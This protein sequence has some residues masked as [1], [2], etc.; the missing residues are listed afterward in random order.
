MKNSLTITVAATLLSSI[1]FAQGDCGSATHLGDAPILA[2][3]FNTSTAT[4][5]GV[6]PG[7][8][9][10]TPPTDL[11]FSFTTNATETSY[12][13]STCGFV[14]YD[15]RLG[16]YDSCGSS[17]I[18]CNDDT[19]GL[20]SAL[21]VHGLS[22]STTYFVQVGGFN[23]AA[24]NGALDITPMMAPPPP[25][26]G[27]DIA[28]SG[29]GASGTINHGLSG[30]R[31]AYSFG[32]TSCNVGDAPVNW[33][34]GIGNDHPVIGQNMFRIDNGRIE[35]LGYSFLKHGFFALSQPGCA[36]TPCQ[37]TNG[38]QLGIGC[39][40]T[41]GPGLNDGTDGASKSSVNAT[42]GTYNGNPGP[43][44]D[45]G[46]I[47]GRLQVKDSELTGTLLIEGQYVSEHD[48]SWGLARNNVSWIRVNASG[49]GN[50]SLSGS[51]TRYEPG[52][53]A[54]RDLA[55]A[56]VND[57]PNIDEGG[58]DVHGWYFV[59][60]DVTD[61]GGGQW[62][63][64]YAVQN[65]NSDQSARSFTIPLPCAGTTTTDMFFRDVD[66]HSGDPYSN[67]DWSFTNNG[68]SAVWSTETFAQNQDANALRWGTLYNFGFTSNGAPQ[69]VTASLGMFKPGVATSVTTTVDGPCA[70]INP[71][72][73]NAINY[74]TGNPNSS[75]PG[76]T[77]SITGSTQ[78]SANDL[79][80]V[81][82]GATP[83]ESGVFYYG[84]SQ[85]DASFGEG[86]RCVGGTTTRLWPPQLANGSGTFTRATD[87]TAAP[88]NGGVG[89]VMAGSVFNF[90][91]WYRDPA[92]GPAGF[93]LSDAI[94]LTFCP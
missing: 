6:N 31:R 35:Q 4:A 89:F 75:G 3:P 71:P 2:H 78:I 37:G 82:T 61:L 21:Q 84:P 20:D 81:A 10:G 88:M 87:Y 52:I 94:E 16:V 86:R 23:S 8:G 72:M 7:C 33:Y 27:P 76:S 11:W 85:I 93:N 40:D 15:S 80:L 47:N 69:A 55:G 49:A 63:Y 74:C 14:N 12:E 64:E 66:H 59:G 19:C 38:S 50:L 30:T 36:A 44:G 25:T 67:T 62:R 22:T 32:T 13:V 70:S 73:C 43:S 56:T 57:V 39:A 46:T 17:A 34:S 51:I 41:Y 60:Y 42:L 1:G 92:G 91:L 48:H 45:P 58:T 54:W 28:L 68:S 29:V 5:S 53:M 9:G 18:E 79:T 65:M 26:I 83:N 24:G 77:I 90:Q